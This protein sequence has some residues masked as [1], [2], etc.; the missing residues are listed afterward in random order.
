MKKITTKPPATTIGIDLG[1]KRCHWCELD[2]DALVSDKGSVATTNEGF[3]KCFGGRPR[4]RIVIEVG[5]HSPWISRLLESHGH[6][7]I[8][9]NARKVKLISQGGKK[10]DR[11]DAETLAR[12]GRADVELLS[13]IRHRG[14]NAQVGRGA[15]ESPRRAGPRAHRTDQ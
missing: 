9:A 10:N 8:V 1:D 3:S 5:T 13:P 14:A 6:E 12:L 15:F 4:S 2:H 7:V 11:H